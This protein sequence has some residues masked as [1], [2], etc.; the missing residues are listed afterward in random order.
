MLTVVHGLDKSLIKSEI[1]RIVKNYPNEAIN[2]LSSTTSLN[3]LDLLVNQVDLFGQTKVYVGY[4]NEVFSNLSSFKQSEK[5][6]HDL[7]KNDKYIIL[8]CFAKIS[9]QTL[10]TQFL[11]SCDTINVKKLDDKLKY[12]YIQDILESQGYHLSSHELDLIDARLINDAAIIQHE[13]AKLFAYKTINEESIINLI[14]DYKQAN[15][16]ELV[17]ACFNANLNT[18]L[19]LYEK[20]F[21]IDPDLN[22]IIHMIGLQLSQMLGFIFLTHQGCSSKEIMN[23]LGL[24]YYLYQNIAI[25]LK[26][27]SKT[28]IYRMI[29]ELYE[30]DVKVKKNLIDK[31]T[32]F[33]HFLLKLFK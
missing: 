17:K 23:L 32:A 18:L 9:S 26:N 22:Y 27:K 11:K 31:N 10:I 3:E 21:K 1:K 13:L 14:C 29:D 5:I 19:D 25:L 8:M 20:F 12:N 30:L 2:Y 33:K 24:N 15:I 7:Q 6:L 16:F 28:L 4:A